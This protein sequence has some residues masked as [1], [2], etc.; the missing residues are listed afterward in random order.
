MFAI[1]LTSSLLW[2]PLDVILLNLISI[3]CLNTLLGLETIRSNPSAIVHMVLAKW[4]ISHLSK[5]VLMALSTI[6]WLITRVGGGEEGHFA[7]SLILNILF[8][9]FLRL[10]PDLN[11]IE[12]LLERWFRSMVG[13]GS[14]PWLII[15]I[16][17]HHKYT[18]CLETGVLDSS[19][20]H[21]CC[22][23]CSYLDKY[24]GYYI[25]FILLVSR[26]LTA[27]MWLYSCISLSVINFRAF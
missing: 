2:I 20:K 15:D 19:F 6:A 5:S 11:P 21:G 18:D 7:I 1:F 9:C 14:C 23:V 3:W 17:R 27:V 24:L 22:S 13:M 10:S 25:I 8:S 12:K 4:H 16:L 26:P